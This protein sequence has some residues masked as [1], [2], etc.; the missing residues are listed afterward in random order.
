MNNPKVSDE[1]KESARY[2]LEQELGGDKPREEIH[3]AQGEGNRDPTR[4]AAGFKAW[5]Q[6]SCPLVWPSFWYRKF[7]ATKNPRVT[8][9]GKEH[10]S[11]K[12]KEMGEAPQE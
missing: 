1:G 5:V 2:K 9:E 7:R 12:L 8:G 3:A 10:A 4:V 6:T 11:Q